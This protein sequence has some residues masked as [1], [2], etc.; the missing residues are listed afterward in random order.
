MV[1][2]TGP[3]VELTHLTPLHEGMS[4]LA[5][6]YRLP[7]ELRFS[8][9]NSAQG[10]TIARALATKNNNKQIKRTLQ[11]DRRCNIIQIR[12]NAQQTPKRRESI[13][14]RR[15]TRTQ[16]AHSTRQPHTV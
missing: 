6:N 13:N 9:R 10:K 7:L 4:D 2:Q 3:A 5:Y 8:L 16:Q 14:A 12:L 15:T 1:R 11:L